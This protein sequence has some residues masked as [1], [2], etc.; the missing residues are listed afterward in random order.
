[1]NVVLVLSREKMQNVRV[2]VRLK[3]RGLK[4]RVMSLLEKDRGR[5]AFELMLKKAEIADYLPPG[6]KP[7]QKPSLILMEDLL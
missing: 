2:M 6:R 7:V 1:M 5:E 3:S 4:K